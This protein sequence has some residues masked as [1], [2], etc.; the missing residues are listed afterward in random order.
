M[1]SRISSNFIRLRNIFVRG[2]LDPIE[3]YQNEKEGLCYVENAKVACTSIK[4]LL[5]QFDDNVGMELHEIAR[6]QAAFSIP[7][8]KYYVFTVVR[9]PFDRLASCYLDKVKKTG[10]SKG[11]SIFDLLFYKAIFYTF[12]GYWYKGE[13]T[14]FD[15]FVN[16]V[17][18]TPDIFSDRH[19]RSQHRI[20]RQL[21]KHGRVYKVLHLEQLSQEWA[22][23]PKL[24][25]TKLPTNEN[26]TGSAGEKEELYLS[27]DTLNKV[28][29]RYRQDIEE[30][31]YQS[32]YEKRLAV[33]N[34]AN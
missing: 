33:L 21:K 23:D 3:Y 25:V 27:V 6:K 26:R 16:M 5:L 24:A 22:N 14:S 8:D 12:S 18:R 32:S 29:N 11:K 4:K 10:A 2:D 13:Q 7:D 15:D 17:L 20:L 9:D 34:G 19:I 30:F 31:G 28:Y 1:L